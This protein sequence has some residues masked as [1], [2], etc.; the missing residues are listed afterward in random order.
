MGD[1]YTDVSVS[2]YNSNP[3]TDDGA[4][5]EANRVKWATIKT[6]LGD[7]LNTAVAAVNTNVGAAVDK[8]AGGIT[9]TAT[10]YTVLAGDQGKTVKVTASA[11]ITTPDATSV[12]SPFVFHVVNLHSAAITL[13]GSGAQTIDGDATI[14]VPAGGGV[15]LETDGSNWFTRGQNFF[16]TQFKSI[17]PQCRLTMTSATP[18]MS[19]GV[20]AGTAV[21]LTPYEGN[22][23]PIPDG[24]D[25]TLTEFT[26]LTL[27]LNASHLANSIYDIFAFDDN[28]T[29][30]LGTGPAW[31]TATAG[32]GSR[33]SGAG[34][35]QLS[36]LKGRYVNTVQITARNG[37]STYSVA[38]GAGLYVGSMAMDG[39]NGQLTCNIG[40]G[41]PRKWGLWNYYNR[42]PVEL[43]VADATASYTYTTATWRQAGGDTDNTLQFIVGLAEELVDM[44]FAVRYEISGQAGGGGNNLVHV[45]IGVNSTT[46]PSGGTGVSQNDND[47]A[48]NT[49]GETLVAF[50]SAHLAIGKHDI[51]A[52]EKVD[53]DGNATFYGTEEFFRLTARMA[54]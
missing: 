15:T 33:G 12:G 29:L 41:Q 39:T 9:A 53:A 38:A 20:A 46:T 16:S 17:Q 2:G 51:N 50:H 21:Y 13:D 44:R 24:S 5:T 28:G 43:I 4:E 1:P 35:T 3:P 47:A 54:T 10:N 7:P 48:G 37:A 25:F 52:L 45:G 8:I 14:S 31:T 6:K 19:S 11:T 36:Q 22:L 34:T 18:V 30:R 26:E 23:L 32:S 42:K 40:S 49:W 27:T